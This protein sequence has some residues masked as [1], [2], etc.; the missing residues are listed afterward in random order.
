MSLR[1][2]VAVIVVLLGC[3]N[4]TKT[5]SDEPTTAKEKQLLEA[6]KSGDKDAGQKSW[7]TWRYSGDRENCFFVVG[8]KCF[9]TEN[10]ACQFARCKAPKKCG[11]VGAGPA[12]VSCK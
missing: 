1:W 4:G 9:K 3:G 5:E 11:S 2:I 7:G 8:R 6:K 10:G 12:T